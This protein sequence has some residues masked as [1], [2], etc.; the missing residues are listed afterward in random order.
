MVETQVSDGE[1]LCSQQHSTYHEILLDVEKA[2]HRVSCAFLFTTLNKFGFGEIFIDWIRTL[3]CSLSASVRTNDHI[4]P[5]F[6]FQSGCPLSPSFF[7]IFIKQLATSMDT[8]I[9]QNINIKRIPMSNSGHAYIR[10]C[11]RFIHFPGRLTQFHT[12]KSFLGSQNG[13]LPGP[14]FPIYSDFCSNYCYS[15]CLWAA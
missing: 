4:S 1:S 3:H 15:Y 5:G 11:T 13:R 6:S 7:A 8:A 2:F 9:Q 14:V 10:L 12:S